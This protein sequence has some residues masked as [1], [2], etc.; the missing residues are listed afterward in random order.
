MG[1]SHIVL[2]PIA[3]ARSI[4]SRAALEERFLACHEEVRGCP[5][6]AQ[7]LHESV[8]RDRRAGSETRADRCGS[9]RCLD[10]KEDGKHME[11]GDGMCTGGIHAGK[12]S[13]RRKACLL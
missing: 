7:R 6:D 9:S 5:M 13:P 12:R 11:N 10:V 1:D 3:R 2:D 4:G 8:G